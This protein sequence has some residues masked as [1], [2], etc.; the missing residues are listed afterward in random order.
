MSDGTLNLPKRN[1][2]PDSPTVDR[3]K[4]FVDGN[5]DEV[6]YIDDLAVVRTF[7]GDQGDQGIQG[8]QGIQGPQGNAGNDGADGATGPTDLVS[9]WTNTSTI[10]LPNTTTKTFV[11]GVTF[12][13]PTVGNYVYTGKIAVRPHSTGNDMEFDLRLDNVVLPDIQVEEHKDTNTAQAMGRPFQGD[14]GSLSAGNHDLDLYF[15][16]ESTGGT[17]QIKYIS[18]FIWRVS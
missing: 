16:K 14:L 3:Y 18:I 17:A 11:D 6:K 12:N 8:I 1:T 15:S 10:T 4:I 7:K 13:V 9:K 5:D 2:N